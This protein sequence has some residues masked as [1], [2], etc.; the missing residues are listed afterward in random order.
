M[1]KYGTH[2][3]HYGWF[4]FCPILGFYDEDD[5]EFNMAPRFLILEPLLWL[6]EEVQHLFN[7]IHE[8][9]NVGFYVWIMPF[10]P[11]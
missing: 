11:K 3:T 9:E 8:E 10:Q 2:F 4:L 7:T 5:G 6:A 1:E